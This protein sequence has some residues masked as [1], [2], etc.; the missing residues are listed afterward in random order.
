MPSLSTS[1]LQLRKITNSDLHNIYIGLSHPEVIP[2]YGVS[3]DSIEAT[4]S[5]LQWYQQL[6]TDDTGIW[7]AICSANDTQFYGAIG[8]NNW[9]KEFK[10]ADIGFW[11][12]PEFWK[13]GFASEAL[14]AV[15]DYGF[16]TMQLH[17]IEAQV[18]TENIASKKSLLKFGFVYEG[19]LRDC[20]IK[21]NQWISLDLFS[22]L[23]TEINKF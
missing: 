17:R 16:N 21:N 12:L 11:L 6:E 18:E 15:C 14:K 7:W 8:F 5:Q 23:N 1:R 9:H 10:K 2:Y 3:Y 4:K 13:Q 19:T 20:E 22:M